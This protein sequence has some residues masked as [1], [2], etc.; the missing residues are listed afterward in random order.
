MLWESRKCRSSPPRDMLLCVW[1]LENGKS[2]L[3]STSCFF[4]LTLSWTSGFS[5]SL[6]YIQIWNCQCKDYR[7]LLT[8]RIDRNAVFLSESTQEHWKIS[9]QWLWKRH[10]TVFVPSG[11]LVTSIS[12]Q[13]VNTDFFFSY[14]CLLW[15]LSGVDLNLCALSLSAK[16][17]LTTNTQE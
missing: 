9:S 12:S 8:L 6:V 4:L 10:W 7:V 3:F 13:T 17:V 1:N 11:S 5:I 15:L 2:S 14:Q 16:L